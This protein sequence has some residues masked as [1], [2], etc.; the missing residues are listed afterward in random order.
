MHSLNGQRQIDYYGPPSDKIVALDGVFLAA[1]KTVCA[2]IR[3]DEVTFDGF[4]LYDLDFSH[5]A[6]LSGFKVGICDIDVTHYSD[7]SFDSQEW[8]RYAKRFL[9]KHGNSIRPNLFRSSGP[10]WTVTPI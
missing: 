2:A 5:R 8:Q 4:H 1:R 6:F 3:F 10:Q 9:A 7:G